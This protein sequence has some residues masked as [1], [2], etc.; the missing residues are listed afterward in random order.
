MT[1]RTYIRN[2]P[3]FHSAKSLLA[4][5][6]IQRHTYP[7]MKSV[8]FLI[9]AVAI[10]FSLP[11]CASSKKKDCCGGSSCSAPSGK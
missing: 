4:F 1:Y 9:A 6:P 8:A 10:A 5:S 2:P 11:A 7:H 3:F